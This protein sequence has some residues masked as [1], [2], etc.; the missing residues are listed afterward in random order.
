M[1]DVRVDDDGN[2]RCWNCGGKNFLNKRTG[3]AHII[4][5][6]TATV[7]AFATKK[8]LKCQQCGEYN[9]VGDAKP[10]DGP[11]DPKRRAEMKRQAAVRWVAE[12]RKNLAASTASS[13]PPDPAPAVGIPA[14]APPAT[15]P[16]LAA[17]LSGL[18]RLR[19]EGVLTDAE[20]Q[21]AKARVLHSAGPAGTTP[22]TTAAWA[23]SPSETST[24]PTP[25]PP[26]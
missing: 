15:L 17:E 19:D 4:G 21:V 12:H 13:P 7:G 10:F 22:T 26:D 6:L 14:T 18:A 3:R 2:L 25:P 24:T 5:Y 11:A 1:N 23:W 9:Q 8:K 20:F 16:S